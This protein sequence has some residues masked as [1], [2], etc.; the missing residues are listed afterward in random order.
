MSYTRNVVLI[1]RII[2][3]L[4]EAAMKFW[5]EMLK[6]FRSM[7]FKHSSADPCL[8]YK[9]TT[10]EFL[11]VWLS[12]INFHHGSTIVHALESMMMLRSQELR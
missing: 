12:W 10:A 9:W 1:L 3:G 2:Y 5:K 4:C 6:A 8:Y 11:I 7:N